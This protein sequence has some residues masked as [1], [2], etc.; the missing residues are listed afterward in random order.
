MRARTRMRGLRPHHL[1]N[2]VRVWP[3]PALRSLY[4]SADSCATG[5]WTSIR[6]LLSIVFMCAL[7]DL[8]VSIEQPL[9]TCCGDRVLTQG[10]HDR[11]APPA[12]VVVRTTARGVGH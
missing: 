4:A 10:I 11:S 9:V 5:N 7:R 3:A 8:R 12:L 6:H 1:P 2:R